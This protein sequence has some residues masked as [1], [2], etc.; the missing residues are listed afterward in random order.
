MNYLKFKKN[1]VYKSNSQQSKQEAHRMG[2]N[3]YY[4]Y[5]SDMGLTSRIYKE[6]QKLNTKEIKML[7]YK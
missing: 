3:F 1:S 2:A 7:I 6:L 5:T 4:C